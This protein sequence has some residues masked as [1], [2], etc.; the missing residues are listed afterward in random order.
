MRN[1]LSYYLLLLI[2]PV[3]FV[4]HGVNENAGLISAS[5]SGRLLLI[6]SAIT[7]VIAVVSYF[8]FRSRARAFFFSFLLLVLYFLFG[9]FKDLVPDTAIFHMLTRYAVLLPLLVI[10][11]LVL[12][13][14]M[15]RRQVHVEKPVKIMS[16]FLLI[17]LTMETGWLVYNLASNA[18]QQQDF[19]DH[20]HQQVKNFRPDIVMNRPDVFWF[21]FDEYAASR[22]LQKVWKF[23]NPLDS[24]L[25]FRQFWVADSAMSNYNVT[26]YSLVS[27]LDMV[28]LNGL[29]Q[30]SV[31]TLKDLARGTYSIY[32]NNVLQVFG[33]AGYAV[34]NHTIFNFKDHISRG[35][36]SFKDVPES[37]LDFQTLGGRIQHDIGWNFPTLLAFNK[38]Q[39]D[40]LVEIRFLQQLDTA[41]D[42]LINRSIRGLEQAA[43]KQD[44]SAFL[45]HFMIPHEPF[46]YNADGTVAYKN[47][48]SIAPENY[49]EHVKY[50]NTVITR[51]VDTI[52]AKYR[53]RDIVIV[54]QG[55]H[56]F[57]F[58]EDDP[59][60]DKESCAILY[61]VYCSDGDYS[62][63]YNTIS[64]VN[65][66]RVL[67][68]KYFNTRFPIL[69]DTSYTLYYRK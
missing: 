47:G 20:H 69:R 42:A 12:V 11:L 41:Y 53:Q 35:M 57:K 4:L 46:M 43:L 67:F 24:M 6:Y 44:P 16:I 49:I 25:R 30:H 14:Y 15:K 21:V 48:F 17:N 59:L 28:Y 34:N 58:R 22:T 1:Y 51:L 68:N 10:L 52:L 2:F 65:G 50:T 31:V 56:G 39:A 23:N 37:L 45:F 7:L 29:H 8:I 18:N 26:H 19:G 5:V 27:T 38:Q 66:F 36:I 40:S 13:M 55:D 9:V 60:Y 62:P 32:D 64:S 33:K 61:A 3:S 54:L 63:W